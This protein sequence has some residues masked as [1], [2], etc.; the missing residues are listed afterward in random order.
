MS[1]EDRLRYWQRRARDAER[2]LQWAKRD[3]EHTTQ[4]AQRA[5]DEQ[6][7]LGDRLTFVYGVAVAHGATHEDLARPEAP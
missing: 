7:R 2:E 3:N 6:R 5:F 1:A 4:W